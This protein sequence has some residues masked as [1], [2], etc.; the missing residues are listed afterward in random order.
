MPRNRPR[1]HSS[2]TSTGAAGWM[3]AGVRPSVDSPP[4]ACLDRAR[5]PVGG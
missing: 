3:S 1:F 5:H 4:H 2:V